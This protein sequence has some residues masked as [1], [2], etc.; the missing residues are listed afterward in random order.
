M[1][2]VEFAIRDGVPYAIDFMNS[3]PD[4]DRASL[5]PEAF[6]WAVKTMADFLIGLAD[7]KKKPVPQWDK[8]IFQ[9]R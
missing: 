6:D 1:N 2:T 4:L 5:T 3:A 8:L 9:A 7:K